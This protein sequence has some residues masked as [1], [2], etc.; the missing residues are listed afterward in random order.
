[1]GWN[2]RRARRQLESITPSSFFLVDEK[3]EAEVEVEAE[4][5]GIKGDQFPTATCLFK[6]NFNHVIPLPHS[7]NDD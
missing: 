7:V 5:E 3:P 4:A 2:R 6:F 1:M